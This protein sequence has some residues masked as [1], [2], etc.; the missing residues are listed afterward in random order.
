MPESR[1][2]RLARWAFN[3][4]PAYRG[5]GARVEYIAADWCE[6]RVRLPL[7]WRTRNYVGTIFGGSLY[8][9][10]D[11]FYMLMLIK[12]LGPEFIVWDKAATIRFLKPGRTTL[13]ATFRLEPGTVE[14]IRVET[15]R[16][17]KLVRDFEVSLVDDAGT[18]HV[19]C[20]KTLYIRWKAAPKPS[21]PPA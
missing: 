19:S 21:L 6:V 7:S 15:I 16:M 10:L 9:A 14:G 4:Y 12:V 13:R 8:G 11:P 2:T 1:A 3:W 17:G 20:T 18:A 5:T